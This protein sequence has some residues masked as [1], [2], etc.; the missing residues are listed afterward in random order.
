MTSDCQ[1][2]EQRIM[3]NGTDHRLTGAGRSPIA[4][5]ILALC[6]LQRWYQVTGQR[7]QLQHL[8]N[9]PDLLRDIGKSRADVLRESG[10]PFWQR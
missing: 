1:A 4:A 2:R 10:K 7:R 8:A 9:D 6:T 3:T 5:L